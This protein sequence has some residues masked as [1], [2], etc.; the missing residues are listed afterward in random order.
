MSA[1]V[2]PVP[3]PADTGLPPKAAQTQPRP[4]GAKEGPDQNQIDL[5]LVIEEDPVSGSYVYKT[6]DRETGEVVQQWPR[7][8]VLKLKQAE[9]YEAGAVIATRA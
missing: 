9:T 1:K 2:T 7:D 5:R 3:S 4:S 6:L 8:E